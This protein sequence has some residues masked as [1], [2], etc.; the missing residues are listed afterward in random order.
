MFKTT[1]LG[2][3]PATTFANFK[4]GL[5]CDD[6]LY[7]QVLQ[8]LRKTQFSHYFSNHKLVFFSLQTKLINKIRK[9]P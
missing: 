5:A 1:P 6:G 7:N 4:Q 8:D 9:K 2:I 3:T